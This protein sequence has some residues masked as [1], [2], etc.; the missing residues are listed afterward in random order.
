MN[1]IVR[2]IYISV[3]MLLCCTPL[4]LMPFV[5]SSGAVGK[6][7]AAENPSLTKNGKI[8]ENFGNEFDAWFTQQMPFRTEIITANNMV[9]SNIRCY[10][11]FGRMDFFRGNR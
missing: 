3:F 5:H 1:K 7:D 11:R 2:V 4:I 10:N 9:S 8:N 6:E